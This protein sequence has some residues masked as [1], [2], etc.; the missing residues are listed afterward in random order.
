MIKIVQEKFPDQVA[1]KYNDYPLTTSNAAAIAFLESSPQQWRDFKFEYLKDAPYYKPWQNYEVIPVEDISQVATKDKI[2]N[3]QQDLSNFL[4]G[5]DGLSCGKYVLVEDLPL[6]TDV[7]RGI[8]YYSDAS[9][10]DM[11]WLDDYDITPG[12]DARPGV[13]PVSHNK[14]GS[15]VFKYLKNTHE[16]SMRFEE[17]DAKILFKIATIFAKSILG[18]EIRLKIK[19]RYSFDKIKDF[20]S[21]ELPPIGC[22]EVIGGR[23]TGVRFDLDSTG[24]RVASYKTDKDGDLVSEMK[25]RVF[26]EKAWLAGSGRIREITLDIK[27]AFES[28]VFDKRVVVTERALKTHIKDPEIKDIVIRALADWGFVGGT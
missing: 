27:F 18:A 6:E 15:I 14:L 21:S 2:D 9:F 4:M 10:T 11:G 8:I 17:N 25:T 20:Q 1:F 19:D 23:L 16:L 24:K 28:R 13:Q 3:F 12:T 7:V 26:Q 5:P 22:Q